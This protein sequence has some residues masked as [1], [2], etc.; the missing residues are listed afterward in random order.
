MA[1][2]IKEKLLAEIEQLSDEEVDQILS[3]E[4]NSKH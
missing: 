2:K 1:N 4:L 3:K